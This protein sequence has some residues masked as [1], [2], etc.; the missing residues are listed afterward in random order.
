MTSPEWKLD[1]ERNEVVIRFPTT[2]PVEVR[3]GVQDIEEA[4]ENLGKCRAQMTPKHATDWKL[5]QQFDAV[6]NP[7]WATEPE[8]L[9]GNSVLHVRDPWFGWLHYMFPRSE[10]RKLGKLLVRQADTPSSEIEKGKPN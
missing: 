9:E 4:I 3:W 8:R 7:I 5:R 1:I 6:I 10:A 2:P